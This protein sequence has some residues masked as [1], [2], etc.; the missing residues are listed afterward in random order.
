MNDAEENRSITALVSGGVDSAVL[1]A[2]LCRS[3][4]RVFPL[5]VRG[6][7]VW[8]VAEH[9]H[10][11]NFLH[12]IARPNLAPL[13][14]LDQPVTDLYGD[15]WSVSGRGAPDA[16][17]P[18]DAVYLPGRNL[19]L[20][21]KAAVWCVLH[22]VQRLA[23]GSLAANPFPDSTPEFDRIV[24]RLV[25]CAMS[26][27]ITIVRPF[28]RL[29]KVDVIRRGAALPLEFTFSCISPVQNEHC[30][31]CNKCA[32]RRRGFARAGVTDRTR[33]AAAPT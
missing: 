32:E 27:R 25:E 13:T 19:F 14:V 20:L 23:L 31:Q 29:N 6:G 2:E 28:L 18:D 15:H 33:Y 24:E 26:R 30:G 17:T 9:N 22:D 8:E 4:R 1:V 12:A 7:L 11:Q 21:A 5:F 10:L 16:T 3:Y